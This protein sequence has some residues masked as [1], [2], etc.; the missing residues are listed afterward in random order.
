AAIS[1][2]ASATIDGRPIAI[3]GSR[4]ETI[5]LWDL[6]AHKPIAQLH[7]HTAAI[8]A[9]ASA[10]IDGR[11][12]AITGSRDETI[13]LWDLKAETGLNART[14]NPHGGGT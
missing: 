13:R 5:R 11:P 12:I 14:V 2:V 8:S 10:T 7:G 1:A 9:V 4:D 3:T 6:I